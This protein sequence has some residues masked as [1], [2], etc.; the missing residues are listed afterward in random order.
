MNIKNL[1]KKKLDTPSYEDKTI[2]YMDRVKSDVEAYGTVK[3]STLDMVNLLKQLKNTP[4]LEC[5][6]D[7]KCTT[8]GSG[9][10]I[11]TSEF[12]YTFRFLDICIDINWWG[13]VLSILANG[14][15]I[16]IGDIGEHVFDIYPNEDYI[17]QFLNAM[18]DDMR[19]YT[20]SMEDKAIK[21]KL[22]VLRA[23]KERVSLLNDADT[24]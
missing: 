13:S 23:I 14:E 18:Y 11:N 20:E 9:E 8:F 21:E 19:K 4:Y 5:K 1:F 15:T 2:S 22:G 12:I 3:F 17:K 24:K 16:A 10:K 6:E 7:V